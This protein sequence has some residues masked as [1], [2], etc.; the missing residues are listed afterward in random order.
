[1]DM[2][3]IVGND[4]M[5]EGHKVGW[6][7]ATRVFSATGKKLGYVQDAKIFN[8]E[9]DKVAYIDGNHLYSQGDTDVRISLDKVNE[10]ISGGVYP[11]AV[12]CAV[13][14]LIGA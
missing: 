6:V 5:R 12:R 13:Y 10:S 1:M 7:E 9:G 4:V 3:K 8:S 11:I 14:V 2:L